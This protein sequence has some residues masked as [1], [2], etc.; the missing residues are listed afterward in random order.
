MFNFQRGV[1]QIPFVLASLLLWVSFAWSLPAE[2]PAAEG[3]ADVAPAGDTWACGNCNAVNDASAKYCK[4]CGAKKA[5]GANAAAKDPWV[6]VMISGAYDYAKCPS[7]GEKNEVRA[8]TCSRCR[9][10]LPQPSGEETGP[11]WVFVPGRGY[12]REGTLLEPGKS[13]KGMLIGGVVSI[14]LGVIALPVLGAVARASSDE[15]GQVLIIPGIMA[16][17]AIGLG[18]VLLIVGLSTRKKPVYA[19]KSGELFEPYDRPAFARRAPQDDDVALKVEVT[20]LG[21]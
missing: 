15:S 9:W 2:A 20:L 7:C 21:F 8:E 18:A 19:F 14:S 11:G 12:F 5:G 6:G 13:R 3:D 16:L 10:E 17:G 1:P 4:E